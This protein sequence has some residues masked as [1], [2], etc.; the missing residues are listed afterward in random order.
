[1]AVQR[2]GRQ[3]TQRRR[4]RDISG[5]A[6]VTL[7]ILV[8]FG[9]QATG[10]QAEAQ[11]REDCKTV[12]LPALRDVVRSKPVTPSA[13]DDFARVHG[14]ALKVSTIRVPTYQAPPRT[15]S[16]TPTP[17]TTGTST[18]KPSARPTPT[19]TPP[20]SRTTASRPTVTA[21]TTYNFQR[22]GASVISWTDGSS[23]WGPNPSCKV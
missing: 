15:T 20:P 19:P 23:Y 22:N 14:L 12:L 18:R 4:L 17:S 6:L 2:P 11:A 1:M 3:R 13:L 21:I 9:F 16:P 5:R 8:G 10:W 7:A